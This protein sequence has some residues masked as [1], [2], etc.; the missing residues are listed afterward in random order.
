MAALAKATPGTGLKQVIA[1][2]VKSKKIGA[3]ST[4]A[5]AS[6]LER[7]GWQWQ[8]ISHVLPMDERIQSARWEFASRYRDVGLGK[9]AIFTDSK[10]FVGGFDRRLQKHTARA[11]APA[12]QPREV[13]KL[14]DGEYQLHVYGGV[15]KYGLTDLTFVSYTT[16]MRP[17]YKNTVHIPVAQRSN[18]AVKTKEVDASGVNHAEYLDILKG[19]GPRGYKGLLPQ[20]KALFEKKGGIT[21]WYWQQDGAKAHT[22]FDTKKGDQTRTT[23]QLFTKNIVEWPPSSPDL[24]P[25]ENVWAELERRLWVGGKAW[26]DRESFKAALLHEWGKLQKDKGYLK[27]LMA[28]VDRRGDGRI[29]QCLANHGGETTY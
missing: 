21:M 15:C 16:G 25:I 8:P 19:G 2:L 27:K 20:A 4:D 26:H 5:Y 6:A 3:H 12:G 24:S 1:P 13:P 28:S 9:R 11:W 14:R 18:P 7:A 29:A 23:I 10:I 22:L 17:A